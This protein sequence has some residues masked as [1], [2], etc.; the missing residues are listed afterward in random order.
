MSDLLTLVQWL[1]PAFPVGSF[2][3]S[4]GME[5]AIAAGDV[6]S[7]DDLAAWLEDILRLGAG[8]SDAI[9][10]A[11][12]LRGEAEDRLA[13]V[14]RALAASRERWEETMAQGRAF[15][16][17]ITGA[18]GTPMDPLPYPVAV[19]VAAR[20]LDLPPAQVAA[21]Y[22]HAVASN[23]VSAAVR[24]VPLGQAE[25]QRVLAGLHATVA[26]IAD[27]AAKARVDDITAFA[28][29]ADLAAM[30]HETMDVRIFRT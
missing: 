4:H 10:L 17:A 8:R 29:R 14:A 20:R 23:L 28:P 5:Q 12:A 19:G 27:Q 26:E 1:S 18:T 13:A 3:Y 21:Q 24:F 9:L 30:R 25:G 16:E 7:A 6:T 2:A 22:L 11:C 15:A